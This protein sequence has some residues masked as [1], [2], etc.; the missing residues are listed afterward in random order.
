MTLLEQCQSWHENEEFQKIIA[1]L[2]ALPAEQRTPELDSELARAY[3]NAAS[4]EDRAYFEKAIALLTPHAEH[5]K[6]DHLWNFRMGYSYYY[7]DR[8]DRALPYFEEA[9]AA[10]PGDA[11]TERMIEGCHKGLSLPLFQRPFRTRVQET[12][13]AFA[14]AE[15]DLRALM[16][17]DADCGEE[18]IAHVEEILR[19]AFDD[20]AFELGK[21]GAKYELILTPESIRTKL[22]SLV[23]FASLAPAS[24]RE[25]WDIRVGRTASLGFALR[26]NDYSVEMEDVAVWFTQE[27]EGIALTLYCEKLLPLLREDEDRAWWMLSTIVDQALGEISAMRLIHDFEIMDT[28]KEEPSIT[29]A[30]LPKA[31]SEAGFSLDSDA[32]DYL[33]HSYLAYTRDPDTSAEEDW[34]LDVYTGSTR[35]PALLSAYMENDATLVNMYHADGIAAGFLAYPLPED[36]HGKSEEILDF[37]DTLMEAITETAGADAVTFLGGAMGT[38]CGYLDFIAWDLRAVLDA[39]VHFLTETTLPWAL[40]HSFRRDANPIYLLDRTEEDQES[41]APAATSLLSPAAV[42]K[43]EALDDGSTGYFYKML[44]YLEQYIKNGVIKGNFT[45]EEA[46]ADLDIALWYAYACNNIDAYEYYYRTTQW[47][48]AAEKNARGCGTYYY[49]YAVALMYCGRLADALRAAE[50]GAQEEPDYPWTY[51]QLGKLLAHFGDRDGA[52]DAVQKGLAIV[53]DDHE[54][55]TL[56]REIEAGATIEQMSYHWIDPTFDEELQEAASG[57]KLGLRDGVD[58]DGEMYDKQRAIACMTV[59]EAGLAYFRQLFRPDP[60]SYEKNAPYCSFAYPVGDTSVRLVFRMN[61]A[62][63]SKRGPA[64]LRTQKERLDDG[65]WLSRVDEKGTGALSAVHFELDNQVTLEYQYPWQDKN[66][67]IPLD[68]DGNPRDDG[69]T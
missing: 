13:A 32:E 37:R 9:L 51:L 1:E 54:F 31:L 16:D 15:A 33:E 30:C 65:R 2:E 53:P 21:G 61:E 64:W 27:G 14:Q 4:V 41:G 46:R 22:F 66:L 5:F 50:K 24:V 49:R 17:S 69:E 20:V 55:L 52:L 35:L 57:E 68:E 10:L 12:W 42:K 29:L 67:Y 59:N 43:M 11:D 40:F 44:K 6:G 26:T 38:G 34:R 48:P 28:P 60:K 8:E 58:A 19:I 39:A 7:L 63:L 36:L 56:E 18:L 25:H 45:R 62:G 23:Y 47:M 3:N